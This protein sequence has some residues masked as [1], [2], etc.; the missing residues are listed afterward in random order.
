KPRATPEWAPAQ[1]GPD[2]RLAAGT[3]EAIG[4]SLAQRLADPSRFGNGRA[5][6]IFLRRLAALQA[7][8]STAAGPRTR[9]RRGDDTV[10][11][12]RSISAASHKT[13]RE[14]TDCK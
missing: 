2:V 3:C 9:I 14:K 4:A 6:N 1:G 13:C 7:R 5:A 11:C 10:F 8:R 12:R